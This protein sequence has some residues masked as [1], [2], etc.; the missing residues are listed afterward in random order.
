MSKRKK[1]SDFLRT[2]AGNA[3]MF[4]ASYCD[5]VRFDHR[6]Q[7]W[8][9]WD[10]TLRRWVEDRQDKVRVLMKN[11]FRHRMRLAV[12]APETEERA[13][14]IKW[15]LQSESYYRI[16]KALELAKS[17]PPISDPG[18][19]WDADPLLLG[20]ANGILDL[21]TGKLRNATQQDRVTKFSPVVFDPGAECPHWL[22]FLEEIFGGDHELIRFMQKAVGY[23]LTGNVEEHCLFALYGTGRNGKTTF[24]ETILYLMGEYGVDLPFSNLDTKHYPIG[25]GVN[26]PGARFAKS[27]ETRKGRHLDEGRVKSWTGGDTISVRPLHRNAFS[28]QPT[29]KFWLAFNHKPEI[30]DTSPAMWNRI[31]LI[32]FGQKFEKH[33]ADKKLVGTLKAEASG[34]LNWAIKGCLA[35][36]RDGLEAPATVEQATHQY[37]QESDALAPFIADCCEVGSGFHVASGEL[38]NAYQTY[39][40]DNGMKAMSQKEFSDCLDEKGFQAERTG[41]KRVRIRTEL[42]LRQGTADTRT[43]ADTTLGL[44]PIGK[45]HIEENR[46]SRPHVSARPQ[47]DTIEQLLEQLGDGPRERINSDAPCRG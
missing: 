42:R 6:Q 23:T 26:L 44:I 38:W 46:N 22:K 28:F 29:H 16:E 40:D 7:R 5:N 1:P 11:I 20:V 15:A 10:K 24:L 43:D 41:H 3:E 13:K 25:E 12:K 21:R 4:A 19:G 37:E 45:S 35:W 36:Q 2:D 34:I 18:D 33:K 17:E 30:T 39:C 27:V 14:E 9:I 47:S 32:P 8:L 31:R